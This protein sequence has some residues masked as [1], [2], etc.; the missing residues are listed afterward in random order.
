MNNYYKE[1]AK[2]KILSE[3]RKEQRL[4]RKYNKTLKEMFEKLN[5]QS[6]KD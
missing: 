3:K 5:I 6:K 4:A 1:K 2:L